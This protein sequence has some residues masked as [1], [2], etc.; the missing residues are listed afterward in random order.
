[1]I[2]KVFAIN[3]NA[4]GDIIG[5]NN[6]FLGNI[7]QFTNNTYKLRVFFADNFPPNLTVSA[8]IERADETVASYIMPYVVEE[9][10][11]G[12]TL[13]FS[14]WAADIVGDLN[15]SITAT[16][17]EATVSVFGVVKFSVE[18][19]VRTVTFD[20]ADF[21]DEYADIL[22]ALATKVNKT[23]QIN[24]Y[25]LQGNITLALSDF[26]NDVPYLLA[27]DLSGFVPIT[28]TING[29]T[30]ANDITLLTS[31]ITN[32]SG[33][34]TS[35]ALTPYAL[36]TSVPTAVSQLTNDS[37]FQ[38]QTQ[39]KDVFKDFSFT[40]A[41]ST[42]VLTLQFT[43]YDG[44]T[45]TKTIDLPT[46]LLIQSG[47]YDDETKEIVLVLAN[48]TEENPSE[49]RIDAEDLLNLYFADDSTLQLYTD[50]ED[51]NKLKFRIKQTWIDA[52]ITTKL[53]TNGNGS[54]VT[55][56]FTMNS[57]KVNIATGDTLAVIFSKIS[58]YLNDLGTL[59]YKSSILVADLP[60]G[61]V[62]DAN[63]VHTDNNL[64]NQLVTDINGN[65]T[66]R[67][68]HTNK[69][70]LDLITGINSNFNEEYNANDIPTSGAVV[71]LLGF[72]D[73][74]WDGDALTLDGFDSS[75]GD[76]A[77]TIPVRDSERGLQISGVK[78]ST[79]T[80][81]TMAPGVITWNAADGTMDVGLN[82][83]VVLQLGQETL[84]QTRN[85]TGSTILNGTAV[86]CTGVT[87]GSGRM[88]ISPAIGTIDPVTFLGLATQDINNGVNGLVTHF[89]YVRGLDTRG[90]VASSI[91]VGNED[92]NVGD[93]LYVHPTVAGKLT[94][95]EPQ[96]PNVKICVASVII[97][98]QST[99]VLFVR[100]TSNLD[101]T[102]LSDVQIGTLTNNDLLA[103]NSTLEIWENKNPDE[104]NL[105]SNFIDGGAPD[106]VYL[107]SDTLDGGSPDSVYA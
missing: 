70:T 76:L 57:T 9:G 32:N 96:A 4:D 80:P 37:Q 79:A 72:P 16:N 90:T 19:S 68:T 66:A 6:L 25:D 24:G 39:L 78:I 84:Y 36:I 21:P 1:M 38:T 35:S 44:T 91:A 40:Y 28:R 27:S 77:S 7:K 41:A 20:A 58:K 67:H 46:E 74:E 89:G 73:I 26:E 103:Y 34:I 64:T 33:Y 104:L 100:P 43:Q 17:A 51:N 83:D 81:V 59:A 62:V 69:S 42:G 88:E 47:Y 61:T 23:Q 10:V 5:G 54:N 65:T 3:F 101:L 85:A 75:V 8:N 94:K 22:Q 102:K 105:T 49:I 45:E 52:N 15:V 29:K 48:N 11:G 55:A 82:N 18:Y 12:Y 63:Y 93:K 30:L 31:D 2:T 99:G 14:G 60:T 97:K 98:H 106:S 13:L 50:T 87:A 86:Y 92:W 95:V 107:L 53:D 71:A 56:V